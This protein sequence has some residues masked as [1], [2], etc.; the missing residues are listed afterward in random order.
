MALTAKLASIDD[1]LQGRCGTVS[2]GDVLAFSGV[3]KVDAFIQGATHS[4]ISHVAVLVRQQPGG[5]MLVL[6]STARGITLTPLIELLAD[7][8]SDHTCFYLPLSAASRARVV[9]A[10]LT[11]Y[12]E[13]Y[14][15]GNYNYDGVV[16]AGIY[17]SSD[18]L[19]ERF[20]GAFHDPSS[21]VR[22]LD[23]ASDA[24][25][26]RGVWAEVIGRNPETR[27]LM[28]AQ[29]VT[30]VLQASKVVEL[31]PQSHRLAPIEV[32]SF[33]IF[34]GA[35]QLNGQSAIPDAFKWGEAPV[36]PRQEEP[37]QDDAQPAQE[38]G[39]PLDGAKESVS[40]SSVVPEAVVPGSEFL[41]DVVLHRSNYSV[42]AG[43]GAVAN[44]ERTVLLCDGAELTASI[45]LD[46][47]QDRAFEME[48][49]EATIR[50]LPPWTA[51]S[52]RVRATP[53]APLGSTYLRV[54]LGTPDIL[55]TRFYL[56]IRVAEKGCESA[57]K[58]YQ[59]LE[60][61][62]RTAF[63]SYATANRAEVCRRLETVEALGIDV[64]VDCL[65]IQQ[66]ADWK[67]VLERTVVAKDVFLLFWSK[68]ASLSPWVQRE[69]QTALATRGIDYI[70]PNALEPVSDCPPPKELSSLQFGSRFRLAR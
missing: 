4:L 14:V 56:E 30:E 35:Y 26:M 65:D 25:Q 42:E 39:P 66:G 40:V 28:S 27:R 3:S 69:W 2:V 55:L 57:R 29:V 53:D 61:L 41:V 63:A 18:P 6:E 33:G 13:K 36:A 20:L 15:V 46:E 59:V 60:K 38:D 10:E 67:K 8:Q 12:Y 44:A 47:R 17:P 19:L 23:S 37:G 32:C 24:G 31:P 16:E 52:F 50:W 45:Y 5:P 43:L 49:A 68:A 1:L 70:V 34:A 54:E 11:A 21:P 48:R 62:P 64:F 7:Y 22:T 9:P 58:R 51:A